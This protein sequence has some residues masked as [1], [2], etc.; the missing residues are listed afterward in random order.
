MSKNIKNIKNLPKLIAL[1]ISLSFMANFFLSVFAQTKQKDDKE[2]SKLGY[3]LKLAGEPVNKWPNLTL[4]F[5]IEREDKK[6]FS[7]LNKDDIEI[8][9]DKKILKEDKYKLKDGKEDNTSVLFLVDRSLSMINF[10]PGANKLIAAKSAL[11]SF[12]S[13][14]LPED[15][16]G[17]IAFDEEP[18]WV[19]EISKDKNKLKEDVKNFNVRTDRAGTALYNSLLFAID[20]AHKNK[21]DN[22]VL[23]SDGMDLN[24]QTVSLTPQERENYNRQYEQKVCQAAID[25]NLR[26]FTIAIG[27]TDPQ[28]PATYVEYKALSMLSQLTSGG[29][30]NLIEMSKL[31]A[32]AKGD[33]SAYQKFLEEQLK[34]ELEKIRQYF[35]YNYSLSLDLTKVAKQD[36]KP[37]TL[38]IIFTIDDK[39]KLPL[40]I[41]FS[42]AKNTNRPEIT[43][44]KVLPMIK[45]PTKNIS[46]GLLRIYFPLLVLLI[47][48]SLIPY[49]YDRVIQSLEL[50]KAEKLVTALPANSPFLGQACPNEGDDPYGLAY[51]FKAGDEVI[52]CPN[53]S[54][55]QHVNCFFFNKQQ[56]YFRD[57]QK[58]IQLPD[59]VVKKYQNLSSQS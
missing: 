16:A 20:V 57:C 4:N 13:N 30:C 42:W 41:T 32:M 51:A 3:L 50:K 28:D 25:N 12:L 19:A 26:I 17:V 40:E 54:R 53:C 59:S 31:E 29:N 36:D 43:K 18:C 34:N 22:I 56:C 9:L 38:S 15:T 14:M 6:V 46:L 45:L 10:R 11:I 8:K 21:I 1:L 39:V 2:V 37:H 52:V 48:L 5:S 24:V 27:N 49:S 23:V 44:Y 35:V 55:P 33:S 47:L 7:S 58:S